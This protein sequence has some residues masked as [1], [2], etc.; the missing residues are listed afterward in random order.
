MERISRASFL[1]YFQM[2]KV[3]TK[4]Q[5]SN[6]V[7]NNLKEEKEI[8]TRHLAAQISIQSNDCSRFFKPHHKKPSCT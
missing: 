1:I 2:T 5:L 8:N 4:V 7:A 6:P 3:Y